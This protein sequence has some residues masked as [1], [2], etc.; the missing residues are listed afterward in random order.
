MG[1]QLSLLWSDWLFIA[2]LILAAIVFFIGRQKEHWRAPWRQVGQSKVGMI[3]LVILLTY[4][5]ITLA[6]SIHF[7][8]ADNYPAQQ[9]VLDFAFGSLATAQETSYS[10]PFATQLLSPR[11]VTDASGKATRVYPDVRYVKQKRS[12]STVWL[13]IIVSYALLTAVMVWWWWLLARSYHVGLWS[14]YKRILRGDTRLAW[15][16]AMTTFKIMWVLITVVLILSRYYHILGTD[17]IGRDVF[18]LTVKSIRTGVLIG[19]L[20]TLF[21]LPFAMVL[22]TLAGYFRGWVDDIIQYVYTTLSSIPGVLLITAAVLVLQVTIA[23]NPTWFTTLPQRADA[24][25]LAL[26]IILGITSWTSLC[27]LLRG[28]TL[29]L[30]EM[31]YVQA[32]R[33]MGSGRWAI[34]RRHVMPNVMHIVMIT[35]VLDFSGLVLAEAI[36]SYVGV[37]VDP[38]TISWGHMIN[39]SRLELARDPM[40]WWP[41]V[42]ALIAMFILVLS[43]NLFAD[44]VRDAFDPRNQ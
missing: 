22:G 1:W 9:S 14:M 30:R 29:K 7:Y 3:T 36:L 31:E 23:N 16:E 21:M 42:S 28:E 44:R 32:A 17:K 2:L 6:D 19:T 35:L 41:L 40:V 33:V 18:Y 26:C 15:R 4:G 8:K 12:E 34:L 10:A 24:R 39:S 43:A 11:L 20:T 25:L 37:G 5:L 38:T 27:R 13:I